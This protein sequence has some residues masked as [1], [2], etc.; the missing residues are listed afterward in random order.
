[1]NDIEKQ[2]Q[3]IFDEYGKEIELYQKKQE[4]LYISGE[5]L[6]KHEISPL[7]RAKM[8]DWM[9]EVLTS[10]NCSDKT[11]F[12][13]IRIMDQY[14]KQTETKKLTDDLHLIGVTSMFLASKYEDVYP[15]HMKVIY[16]K[17]AHKKLETKVILNCEY[18][19]LKTLQYSLQI[20]TIYEFARR[21][22]NRIQVKTDKKLIEKLTIYLLKMCSHDYSFCSLKPSLIAIGSIYIG[23]KICEQIKQITLLNKGFTKTMIIVSGYN[24]DDIIECAQKILKLSQNFERQFIGLVNLRKY[25]LIDF[26]EITIKNLYIIL[27]SFYII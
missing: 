5:C 19:I 12:L 14:L 21:Y 26:P 9:I 3:I 20:P 7:L 17:I 22:L 4:E 13:A 15:L 23:V 11:F 6:K 25:S 10:F 27:R 1:M 24:E 16:E 18:D 2:T 8:V